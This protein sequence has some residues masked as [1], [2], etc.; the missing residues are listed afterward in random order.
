MKFDFSHARLTRRAIYRKLDFLLTTQRAGWQNFHDRELEFNVPDLPTTLKPLARGQNYTELDVLQLFLSDEVVERDILLPVNT[1]LRDHCQNASDAARC[2]MNPL[3][4][5]TWWLFFAKYLLNHLLDRG[6][7][8]NRVGAVEQ[9]ANETVGKAR[10]RAIFTA[11]SF[12][13]QHIQH[14]AG[15]MRSQTMDIFA[16]GNTVVVDEAIFEYFGED[17]R[18]AGIAVNIPHKP[19]PYG[20]L[21]HLACAQL[22]WSK[23]PILVDWEPRTPNNKLAP[24]D[25]FL[26]IS[27]RLGTHLPASSHFVA[28]SG[29]AAATSLAAFDSLRSELTVAISTSNSC[30]M[31]ELYDFG[32]LSSSR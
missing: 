14:L 4:L 13:E 27:H 26:R 8:Q 3:S 29:F 31:K 2:R 25:A 23:L 5:N 20:L 16:L 11:H 18:K 30:G 24:V 32:S 15:T 17:M 21:C 9:L 28:D 12:P 6:A 22:L 10:Y 7:T 1:Y 19:H